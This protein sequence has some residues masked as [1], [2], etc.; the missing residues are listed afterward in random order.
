[1]AVCA[2][3]GTKG[4]TFVLKVKRW[5]MLSK[6]LQRY[7][8]KW[9]GLADVEKR[10]RQRHLDLIVSPPRPGRPSAAAQSP[11]QLHPPLAR[12]SANFWRS[13]TP[14]A[15]CRGTRADGRPFTNTTTPSICRLSCGRHRSSTSSD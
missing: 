12:L 11:R 9:H 4:R 13:E 2:A 8:D 1:M 10:Y 14:R 5:E 15:Q 3:P 6:A 7:A